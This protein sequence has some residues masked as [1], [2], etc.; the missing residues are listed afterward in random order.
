MK[1]KW[2]PA[3]SYA[4]I[5]TVRHEDG[6]YTSA[7][8]TDAGNVALV[9]VTDLATTPSGLERFRCTAFFPNKT[10]AKHWVVDKLMPKMLNTV[11]SARSFPAEPK[12]EPVI[13][14]M[15]DLG[16]V[17][18]DREKVDMSFFMHSLNSQMDGAVHVTASDATDEFHVGMIVAS[19]EEAKLWA[20]SF[21]RKVRP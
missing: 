2:S 15:G 7:E 8:I 18:D 12:R 3:E 16:V 14:W 4:E 21:V 10:E 13:D 17:E 11:P 1:I 5:T 20:A 9:S 6:T 19:R